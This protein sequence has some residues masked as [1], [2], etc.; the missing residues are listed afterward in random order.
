MAG[1]T[2]TR[3]DLGEAVYQEIGLSRNESADLLESVLEYMAD[4]LVKGETVKVS[5]AAPKDLWPCVADAGQLENA[6]F[7]LAINARDAIMDR[8][9]KE[10]TQAFEKKI[11]LR[12]HYEQNKVSLDVCDTGIG[13]PPSIVEKIFEPFF[14]TKEVGKG[15]GLGL[16]ISY[17]IIKDFGG[18]IRVVKN[19]PQGTCFAITFPVKLA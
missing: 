7:N 19:E 1:K 2:V 4:A 14:T 17:G 10:D 11:F 5:I 13:I 8:A 15:T 9:E 12:T 18:N 16:S 6:I 3:A